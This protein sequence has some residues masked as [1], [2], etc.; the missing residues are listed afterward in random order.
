MY[1]IVCKLGGANANATW[2]NGHV[3]ASTSGKLKRGGPYMPDTLHLTGKL[4]H[5]KDGQH[6]IP[7]SQAKH[8]TPSQGNLD[9]VS[10][11]AVQDR[12][13][14]TTRPKDQASFIGN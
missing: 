9:C 6:P 3:R 1:C 10:A 12:W 14:R 2:M 5:E 11:A 8:A 4:G 7:P 13:C